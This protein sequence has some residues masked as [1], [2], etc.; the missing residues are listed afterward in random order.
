M[1]ICVY[2]YIFVCRKA[3]VGFILLYF[4]FICS[5]SFLVVVQLINITLLI[6]CEFGVWLQYISLV[7]L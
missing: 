6:Q 7:V 4:D 3:A 1:P 5:F 2:I